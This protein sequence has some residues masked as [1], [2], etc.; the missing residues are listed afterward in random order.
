MWGDICHLP[1]S[2]P[3][4]SVYHLGY[5][6]HTQPSTNPKSA[7]LPKG[8]V[9]QLVLHA[10]PGPTS[11]WRLTVHASIAKAL[12]SHKVHKSTPPATFF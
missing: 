10:L 11:S 8:S 5:A 3:S 2:S 4:E 7:L 12:R 1:T 6:V 9:V